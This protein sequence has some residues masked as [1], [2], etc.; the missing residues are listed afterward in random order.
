MTKQFK[1][2]YNMFWLRYQNGIEV[3][4]SVQSVNRT[5]IVMTTNDSPCTHL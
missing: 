4:M 5:V 3:I 2:L 1:E